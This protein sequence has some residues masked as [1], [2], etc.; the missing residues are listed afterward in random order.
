M[1]RPVLSKSI[2]VMKAEWVLLSEY[3]EEKGPLPQ[4]LLYG[5]GIR[6]RRS[7]DQA[8]SQMTVYLYDLPINR[9]KISSALHKKRTVAEKKQPNADVW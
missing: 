9:A 6:M 2:E 7:A 1:K 4:G 5:S 3:L 8:D